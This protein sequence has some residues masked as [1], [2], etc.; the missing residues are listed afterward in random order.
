VGYGNTM[1]LGG[2]T[3]RVRGNADAVGTI[4]NG[5]VWESGTGALMRGTF[6]AVQV[7]GSASLQGSMKTTGAVSV[8]GSLAVK[9]QALS[10]QIP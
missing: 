10:I 9:N 8:T 2:F 4:A 1:D 7:T 5:T 6:N 3:L